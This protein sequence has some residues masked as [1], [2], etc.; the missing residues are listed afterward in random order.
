MQIGS[1]L[2]TRMARLNDEYFTPGALQKARGAFDRQLEDWP[3]PNGGVVT[4]KR[5]H[6]PAGQRYFRFADGTRP[7]PAQKYGGWW[8]E[9]ETL[10][11]IVRFARQHSDPR[12]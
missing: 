8:I 11:K 3:E 1:L 12:H 10:T 7:V 2:R 9:Y 6:L 5:V 4:P